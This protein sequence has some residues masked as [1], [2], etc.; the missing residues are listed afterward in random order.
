MTFQISRFQGNVYK[1]SLSVLFLMSHPPSQTSGPFVPLPSRRRPIS[2]HIAASSATGVA[3]VSS[4]LGGKSLASQRSPSNL[5]FPE[6]RSRTP[7]M[8]SRKMAPK[9]KSSSAADVAIL[10]RSERQKTVREKCDDIFEVSDD[11]AKFGCP[12]ITK[13]SN[14]FS[15]AGRLGKDRLGFFKSIGACKL[16]LDTLEFGH[17]PVLS[18]EVP[19]Y[20]R[21]NNKSY[22]EHLDFAAG[23]IDSLISSGKV[24]IIDRK[25]KIVNPLSVAIQPSKKRLVLDCSFLNK[26]VVAPPFKMD[27]VKAG[28]SFFK[29]GAFMVTF[30]LKDGYHHISIHESFKD[31]LGFSFLRE[32]KLVYARFVVAPFGLR[33]VPYLFTKIL[34]PLVSHWRRIGFECAIYLDDGFSCAQDR[35][36]AQL[37][38]IHIREDLMRAG[39]VWSIK[40]SQWD[41]AQEVDWIGYIW[42][43][44][45][46]TLRIRD[47]RVVKLKETCSALLKLNNCPA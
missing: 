21:G 11:C 15:V 9:G 13:M 22:Y 17:K 44:I 12:D 43:S 10:Q 2:A 23:E 3:P 5:G 45:S 38:S 19:S 35:E 28:L 26:F 32:G 7:V 34:R 1:Q 46:G 40:K 6:S 20:D 30:D 42:N 24:E 27:D 18:G 39:L 29:K 14:D 37:A 25:P 8:A 31:Y 16:V 33:D 41:P 4:S 47:R 36:E